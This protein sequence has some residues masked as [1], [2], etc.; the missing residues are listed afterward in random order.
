MCAACL[1]NIVSN[2][3]Y[4]LM[5]TM[6]VFYCQPQL[7]DVLNARALSAHMYRVSRSVFFFVKCRNFF[8]RMLS[9]CRQAEFLKTFFFFNF[10]FWSASK[11]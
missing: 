10:V 2:A 4:I 5:R 1:Y 11:F 9:V 3:I 7:I 8:V 6:V